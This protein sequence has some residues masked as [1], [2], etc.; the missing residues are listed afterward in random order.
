[1]L[2]IFSYHEHKYVR[3][4]PAIC[5]EKNELTQEALGED[6][7]AIYSSSAL[8]FHYVSILAL[9]PMARL[10]L[11]LLESV[12]SRTTTARSVVAKTD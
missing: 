3:I 9:R 7:G 11:Y 4:Y 6:R 1:M 10:L 2:S 8:R 5:Y 12:E